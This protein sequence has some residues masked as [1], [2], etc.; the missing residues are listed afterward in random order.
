M[1][2]CFCGVEEIDGHNAEPLR[3]GGRCC[4]DCNR[5][6]SAERIIHGG[7][8]PQFAKDLAEVLSRIQTYNRRSY[9]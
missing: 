8:R 7:Y 9:D 6:V 2:C 3:E 4:T 1:K 5:S